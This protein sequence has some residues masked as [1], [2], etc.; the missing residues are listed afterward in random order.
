M[1]YF[2]VPKLAITSHRLEPTRYLLDALAYSLAYLI[3]VMPGSAFIH[4]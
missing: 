4:N 2:V 1:L 3:P